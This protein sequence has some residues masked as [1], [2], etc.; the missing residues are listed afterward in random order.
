MVGEAVAILALCGALTGLTPVAVLARGFSRPVELPSGHGYVLPW[1]FAINDRGQALAASGGH[2][3]PVEAT[4]RLGTPWPLAVPGGFEPSVGSLVLD[5][6]GRVAAGI[7]YSDYSDTPEDSAHNPTCCAHVAVASWEFGNSPPL[8]QVL[9]PTRDH[10]RYTNEEL[11]APEVV[12]GPT[13][14]TVMWS[15]GGVDPRGEPFEAH[16]DE[17]YGRFGQPLEALQTMSVP[18]GIQSVHLALAPDGR[19]VASWR[20]DTNEIVTVMGSA[21]GRLPR[22]T[23]AQRA[24]RFSKDRSLET[25]E[26]TT[27]LQGDTVFTYLTGAFEGPSSL[28]AMTSTNGRRFGRPRVI[29]RTGPEALAPRV[30]AGERRSILAFWSC[31]AHTRRCSTTWGRRADLF[32]SLGAP[33]KVGRYPEGFID[34]RGRTVV[35]YDHGYSSVEAI[36]A[37]PGGQFGRPQRISPFREE[38]ELDTGG[39]AEPP[40]AASRNGAAI[41]YITC[42]GGDHEYL[43]RYT[44]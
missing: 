19:P 6:R 4:G 30:V 35:L 44:P 18:R 13:A 21:T 24:P 38:C 25:G 27:D 43:M 36:T 10:T 20:E 1:T 42:G 17:A 3:Y 26:F 15:A 16:L 29:A 32:G 28:M 34:S 9:V 2:V 31:L 5:D 8:A 22:P 12:I 14:V 23:H 11:H 7:Y 40:V 37:A 39:D 41:F 33:F